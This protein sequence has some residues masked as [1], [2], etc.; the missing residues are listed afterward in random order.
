MDKSEGRGAEKYVLRTYQNGDEFELA[1]VFNGAYRAYA[2]F[3][4]R[5]ADYWRWNCL[6]RPDVDKEGIVIAIQGGKIVAYAVVGKSGNIWELCFD[7][8]HDGEALVS[9]I[10]EKAVEYLTRIGSDAATLN[11]PYDDSVAREACEKAGF[12]ELPPDPGIILLSVLDYEPFVRLLSSIKEEKFNGFEGNFLI[13]LRDARF[14]LNPLISIRLQNGRMET[15]GESKRGDVVIETDTSTLTSIL[16][17]AS[18]PLWAL[19]RFKL[20]I[21]PLRKLGKVLKLLGLLRLDDPWF[22]ARADLG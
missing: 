2:G 13:K 12:S 18:N 5:T 8:A 14:W 22:L 15:G 9:L 11:L 16:F 6:D 20:K 17:G 10:L 3:V 19:F 7:R 21:R 4:P 1:Q